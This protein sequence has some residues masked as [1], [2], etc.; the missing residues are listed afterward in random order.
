VKDTTVQPDGLTPYQTLVFQCAETVLLRVARTE[1]VVA[2]QSKKQNSK[3]LGRSQVDRI[4][5]QV[6]PLQSWEKTSPSTVKMTSNL[7]SARGYSASAPQ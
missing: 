5:R 1:D 4:V 7:Y 3:R 6:K 2:K